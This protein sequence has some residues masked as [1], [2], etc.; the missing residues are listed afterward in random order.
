M[1][2]RAGNEVIARVD[3]L[4]DLLAREEG[5][6]LVEARG[7]V[8]RA[9]QILKFHGGQALRNTGELIDSIRPGLEVTVTR[10]PLGVV[11]VITPWNFPIAIPAWKIAPALAYGNTACS[12]RQS[13]C[14]EARGSSSTS[15]VA[16]D[17]R[18]VCSTWSWA[19]GARWGRC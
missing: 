9:G 12:S 3:E 19:G 7:E 11:G 16:P 15:C 18:T 13:S 2:D 14:R 8:V 1:L 6:T 4:G 17:F 10:E 5:K